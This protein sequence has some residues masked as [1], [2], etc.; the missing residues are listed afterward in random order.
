MCKRESER[1]QTAI[2]DDAVVTIY[3]VL[4]IDFLH[5]IKLNGNL[6]FLQ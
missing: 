2:C 6:N 4:T 3:S 1:E 5:F